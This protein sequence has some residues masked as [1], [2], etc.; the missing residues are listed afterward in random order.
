MEK[1]DEIKEQVNEEIKLNEIEELIKNKVTTF[2]YKG[3]SYRVRPLTFKDRNLGYEKKVEKYTELLSNSKFK[4]E[5][6]LKK[7]YKDSRNID[8]DEMQ[9]R[10]NSLEAQISNFMEQLGKLVK[11]DASIDQKKHLTDKIGELRSSQDNI[12][13]KKSELLQYSVE[14]QVML[15]VYNFLTYLCTEKKEGE[16]WIPV[17]NSFEEYQNYPDEKLITNA[18]VRASLVVGVI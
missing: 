4:L 1:I 5:E 3:Q 7:V 14:S 9:N 12:S 10:Y 16:N 18:S 13:R 11:E 15:Y 2:D 6:D 17:W 8:I